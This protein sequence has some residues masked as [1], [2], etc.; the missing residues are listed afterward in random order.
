WRDRPAEESLRLLREM[1]DGKHPD[2][3]MALRAKIDMGSPNLNLRDPV[4]YR[5]RHVPHHRTGTQW[6][7]YPMYSWAHPVE[8]ALEGITHSICT[9]EFEDQRPVY[10]WI[11]SPLADQGHLRPPLPN[12]YESARLNLRYVVT[13]KRRRLA[14]VREGPVDGWDDPRPPTLAGLRRRGYTP[15]AIRLFC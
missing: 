7:I 12:R 9:L 11:L 15:E 2:G 4:L 1:R 6:C 13:S 5:I 8:D 10:A 3:S 14:L